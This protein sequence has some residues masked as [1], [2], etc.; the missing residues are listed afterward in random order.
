MNCIESYSQR[1]NRAKEVIASA[2]AVVIG[3]GA[4]VSSAAGLLYSGDKFESYFAD[5]V[6]K[7]GFE[8]L[9]TSAFYEFDT[10]EEHWARWAKHINF[11]RHGVGVLPLY[12]ELLRLVSERD[13][14]VIT[15]NADGQFP[16]A[17]FAPE[18]LFVVQGDYTYLQ[19]AKGCHNKVYDNRELVKQMLSTIEDC[20][21]PSELIPRCPVC[22]GAMD[23][24]LRKDEYFVTTEEWEAQ[25]ERYH[26]FNEGLNGSKV[27]YLELGVG[28]NTPTIIRYAFENFVY[29]NPQ[30]TLI[31]LNREFSMA[32]PENRE[33]TI[34]FGENM[35]SVIREFIKI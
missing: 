1:I 23:L 33:R 25:S 9:Y 21:I 5:F 24:H 26:N 12:A 35:T 14:F 30:A 27:V 17:G 7:Y 28:F 31:R 2:D 13:Y 18:R 19:C 4:G 15:T 3:A 34:S 20:M 11:C 32:I 10:E 16:K 29:H 6:A 8:D 22:G